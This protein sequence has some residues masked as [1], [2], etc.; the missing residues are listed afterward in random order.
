M[1]L[2]YNLKWL[3]GKI[4]KFKFLLNLLKCLVYYIGLYVFLLLK[5]IYKGIFFNVYVFNMIF[6]FKL[7]IFGY[8][9]FLVRRKFNCVKEVE[10]I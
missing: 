4:L 5:R 6:L 9:I 2:Y 8:L 7:K 10:K 3:K 1:V